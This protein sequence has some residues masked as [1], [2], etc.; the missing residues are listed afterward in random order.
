MKWEDRYVDGPDYIVKDDI[1]LVMKNFVQITLFRKVGDNC[2]DISFDRRVVNQIKR[3][4]KHFI[5][6]GVEFGLVSSMTF[7][8]KFMRQDDNIITREN[9]RN[10][11]ENYRCSS[12]FKFF[13]REGVDFMSM[14]VI[15]IDETSSHEIFDEEFD[16]INKSVQRNHQ[17][18]YGGPSYYRDSEEIRDVYSSFKRNMKLTQILL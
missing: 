14:L 18:W 3:E 12:F 13:Q 9:I 8:P 7:D 16:K 1:V 10:M 15:Y 5:K 4:M 11:L 2:V 17:D 6:H